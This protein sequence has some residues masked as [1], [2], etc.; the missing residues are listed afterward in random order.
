MNPMLTK[1]RV[2]YW[3][4]L[5]C[6]VPF[7]FPTIRHGEIPNGTKDEFTLGVPSSPWVIASRSETKVETKQE[8]KTGI[9]TSASFRFD[10]NFNV[11]LISWSS[12]F[13]VVGSVLM[14]L[15]RRLNQKPANT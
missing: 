1:A 7:V 3:I 12:L 13:A 5:L 10:Q 4:G 2:L 15:S 9:S 8:T 11:E 6:F 14:T